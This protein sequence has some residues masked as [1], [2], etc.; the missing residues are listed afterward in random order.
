MAVGFRTV[1]R[2]TDSTRLST[3]ICRLPTST[4][5][6]GS[7][8]QARMVLLRLKSM[9]SIPDDCPMKALRDRRRM[10]CLGCILALVSALLSGCTAVS[11]SGAGFSVGTSA[12]RTTGSV[13]GAAVDL[14]GSTVSVGLG[15]GD[16]ST[17][18]EP[19]SEP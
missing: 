19:E 16:E 5:E 18:E 9:T 2:I 10:A 4:D 15:G 1:N 6:V 11:L 14:T 7:S 8:Q 12:V 17:R 13:G 3:R